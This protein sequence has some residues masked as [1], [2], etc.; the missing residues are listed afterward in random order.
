MEASARVAVAAGDAAHAIN[1]TVDDALILRGGSGAGSVAEILATGD[2]NLSTGPFGTLLQGGNVDAADARVIAQRGSIALNSAIA[3]KFFAT[4]SPV[5]NSL[6]LAPTGNMLFIAGQDIIIGN[7]LTA[8][9][10]VDSSLILVVDNNFPTA[11]FIGPGQF[12]LGAGGSISAGV[13]IPVRIYTARRSQNSINNVI[14]GTPFVPGPFDVDSSTEQWSIYYPDGTYEG[15]AFKL[16]YKEPQVI[17][18]PPVN[19]TQTGIFFAAVA[20]NLVQLADLLPVVY[21]RKVGYHFKI[22]QTDAESAYC[23]PIF[24]PYNSFIFEDDLY[25]IGAQ[26]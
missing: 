25:W 14:N 12:I 15:E 20:V 13:G 9:G 10:T 8:N 11:P 23:D 22:C 5:L 19:P 2:V 6:F 17:P 26:F 24:S 4:P 18:P 16:Y 7:A 1:M 3:G 21:T